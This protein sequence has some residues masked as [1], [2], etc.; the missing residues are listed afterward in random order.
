MKLPFSLL[1]TMEAMPQKGYEIFP[2]SL[3]PLISQ[4]PSLHIPFVQTF[5]LSTKVS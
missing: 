2:Q 3:R 5:Y 4:D 1:A